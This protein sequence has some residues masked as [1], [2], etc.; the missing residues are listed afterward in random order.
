MRRDGEVARTT[1][2][3]E[4]ALLEE[5]TTESI[6]ATVLGSGRPT[7]LRRSDAPSHSSVSTRPVNVALDLVELRAVCM[8]CGSTLQEVG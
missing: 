7:S 2:L 3:P 5:R 6:F 1:Y 8:A 4:T